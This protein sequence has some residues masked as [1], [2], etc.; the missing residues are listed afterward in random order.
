MSSIT[1]AEQAALFKQKI[2]SGLSIDEADWEVKRDVL[3]IKNLNRDIKN[4][5]SLNLGL[6]KENLTLSTANIKLKEQISELKKKIIAKTLDK[7]AK[8]TK[9]K[10]IPTPNIYYCRRIVSVLESENKS[11]TVSDLVMACC[12]NNSLITPCL[13]FLLEFQIVKAERDIKGVVRYS[14]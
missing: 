13:K 14:R 5:Q 7:T 9:E 12:S 10:I 4:L 1:K 6:K 2:R 3:F 8:P 11:M